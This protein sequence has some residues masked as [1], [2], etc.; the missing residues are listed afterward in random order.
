MRIPPFCIARPSHAPRPPLP[1]APPFAHVAAGKIF[2]FFSFLCCLRLSSSSD[3]FQKKFVLHLVLLARFFCLELV[4][5]AD[6]WPAIF[7]FV[8]FTFC[9][10][11]SMSLALCLRR[12]GAGWRAR[13]HQRRW[14]CAL[15]V[16]FCVAHVGA[17]LLCCSST[18][19]PHGFMACPWLVA[20]HR[21]VAVRTRTSSR[22]RRLP[23]TRCIVLLP[24]R[25]PPAKVSSDIAD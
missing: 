11:C 24:V 22:R 20:L 15:H 21:A 1:L 12:R 3:F 17:S 14:S 13:R 6:F 10:A 5:N 9:F 18:A 2:Q 23:R 8:G 25:I 16:A 7:V 19:R 4:W